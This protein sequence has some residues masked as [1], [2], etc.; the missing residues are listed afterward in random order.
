MNILINLLLMCVIFD[1][2][3]VIIWRC[4]S[5]PLNT[6]SIPQYPSALM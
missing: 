2:S 4:I 1:L 6:Q 5:Y 3:Q